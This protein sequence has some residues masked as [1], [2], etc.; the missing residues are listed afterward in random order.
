MAD[1]NSVEMLENFGFIEIGCWEPNDDKKGIGKTPYDN[2]KQ[3]SNKAAI[4]AFAVEKIEHPVK[5][6]GIG[7][8]LNRRLNK[9]VTSEKGP[10]DE[11]ERIIKLL[12]DGYSIKIFAFIPSE[13]L[14]K[15]HLYKGLAIDLVRGLEYPLINSFKTYRPYGWNNNH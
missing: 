2:Y 6:F 4:Y 12:K 7:D 15:N 8:P 10:K 1:F 9:Y 11:R 13:E 5:Y 14:S 3:F